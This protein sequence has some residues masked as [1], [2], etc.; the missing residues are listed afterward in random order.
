MTRFFAA[1][2]EPVLRRIPTF[3]SLLGVENR[4]AHWKPYNVFS[5]LRRLQCCRIARNKIK[6]HTC[7][8]VKRKILLPISYTSQRQRY[9]PYNLLQQS[10]C[11]HV[12]I[13]YNMLRIILFN[14]SWT[15]TLYVDIIMLTCWAWTTHCKNQRAGLFYSKTWA[16]F[17]CQRQKLKADALL[18]YIVL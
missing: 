17:Q 18:I 2:R 3:A 7:R 13:N 12:I 5:T 14:L 4:P 15:L 10:L 11:L 6:Q 1:K 16:S 9:F 8:W